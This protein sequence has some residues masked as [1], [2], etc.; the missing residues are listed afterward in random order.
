MHIRLLFCLALAS[1]QNVAYAAAADCFP[2]V[3]AYAS[4]RY[5]AEFRNDENIVLS[6]KK[7]GKAVFDIVEDK[8]SGTNHPRSLL[9]KRAGGYCVVLTTPAVAQLETIA[10]DDSGVPLKFRST[11]QAQPG[12]PQHEI[13][14]T[15]HPASSVYEPGDCREISYVGNKK[16]VKPVQ[17]KS[18]FE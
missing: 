4:K 7:F 3:E 9:S 10:T 12:L 15:F 11:D 13:T 6:K 5:G 16:N 14:Y 18:M 1:I 2:S 8:T 17:C